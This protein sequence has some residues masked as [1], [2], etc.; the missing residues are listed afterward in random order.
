M[1]GKIRYRKISGSHFRST[2]PEVIDIKE[3]HPRHD[4]RYSKIW[5]LSVG[6]WFRGWYATLPE[7]KH[8]GEAIAC[9]E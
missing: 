1:A 7:A 2:G 6:G 9:G 8:Y 3:G 5:K 4:S